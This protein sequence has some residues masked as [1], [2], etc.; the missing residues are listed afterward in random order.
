MI[1]IPEFENY[2]IGEDGRVVNSRKGNTLTP[3]LNEN[4]YLYV[5]LWKENKQY[6]RSVHRLVAAAYLPNPSNRPFVNH[7]DANRANPHRDNLE[8]VTQSENILHAYRLGTMTQKKKLTDEQLEDC[9]GRFLQ[10]ESMTS[11]AADADYALSPLSISLR[12]LAVKKNQ[13]ELFTAELIRQKRQRNVAANADKKRRIHQ[14]SLDGHIEATH[15]SLTAAAHALGKKT[16]GPISNA[17]NGRQKKAY[18]FI[19]KY[20]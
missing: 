5:T 6:P 8:W 14:V 13:V 17:L 12:N 2:L 19:W 7:K 10:G 18:G 3:S 9:L 16:S 1:P 11:L 20:V 4:G 15:E